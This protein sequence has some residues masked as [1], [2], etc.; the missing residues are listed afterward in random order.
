VGT[1]GSIVLSLTI[2]VRVRNRIR[3]AKEAA[4]KTYDRRRMMGGS[5]DDATTAAFMAQAYHICTAFDFFCFPCFAVGC[6]RGDGGSKYARFDE[7]VGYAT[8]GA[9][10]Y[11][12]QFMTGTR[13]GAKRMHPSG[14]VRGNVSTARSMFETG[15]IQPRNFEPPEAA[16][17]PLPLVLPPLPPGSIVPIAPPGAAPI[18]DPAA[19]A[20]AIA[21]AAAATP[22]PPPA[23]GAPGAAPPAGDTPPA[24][25]APGAAPPAEGGAA[26][27]AAA[28]PAD[29]AV[30][31]APAAA[32][33]AA[34]DG[35]A[36]APPAEPA[37]AEAPPPPAADAALQA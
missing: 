5:K 3:P 4:I 34:A 27:P 8:P 20:A 11:R 21:A 26:A 1:L 25:G 15:N 17:P 16:S 35:A 33:G 23:A 19:A 32:D 7:E 30:A 37:A 6:C 28:P 2:C 13:S 24:A 14:S 18:P 9:E 29:P 12:H 22:G 10:S 36:A 31:S